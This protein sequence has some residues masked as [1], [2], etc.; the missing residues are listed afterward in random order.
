MGAQ[1][2]VHRLLRLLGRPAPPGVHP[3]EPPVRRVRVQR[4]DQQ[5]PAARPR[6]PGL[7]VPPRRDA[8]RSEEHTSELQSHVNLVC[9]LPPEKKKSSEAPRQATRRR[10]VLLLTPPISTPA[11]FARTDSI[12]PTQAPHC[13]PSTATATS[14]PPSVC[15]TP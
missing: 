7:P 4:A 1:L 2:P 15:A 5:L 12:S 9:R 6:G 10:R 13:S 11:C 3:G 14:C 8:A